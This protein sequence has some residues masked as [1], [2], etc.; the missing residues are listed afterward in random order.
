M[1]KNNQTEIFERIQEVKNKKLTELDLSNLGLK[2][3]PEEVFSL[4]WLTKLTL[5]GI[6]KTVE[7]F[8]NETSWQEEQ[9]IVEEF[10]ENQNEYKEDEIDIYIE[11]EEEKEK[12]KDNDDEFANEMFGWNDYDPVLEIYESESVEAVIE[13]YYYNNIFKEK[14]E[15]STISNNIQNLINLEELDLHNNNLKKFPEKLLKL[16]KL[17]T[18]NLN[19]NFI[20]NIPPEIVQ[21]SNLKQISINSNYIKELPVELNKTTELRTLDISYNRIEDLTPIKD[22][23]LN[24]TIILKFDNN[25]IKNPPLE[26]LNKGTKIIQDWFNSKKIENNEVKMILVGNTT[27]GKT[28]LINFLIS[29][30]YNDLNNSTH[31][32]GINNWQTNGLNINVWDFGGQE[33]Y[34][35]THK[36]FFSNNAVYLLLW[37][38]LN[39]K[40]SLIPTEIKISGKDKREVLELQHYN[41]NHWI[42]TIRTKIAPNSKI[43]LV[44]NKIDE[45]N[46]HEELPESSIIKENNIENHFAI[47]LKK[48]FLNSQTEITD[49]SYDLQF[50]LF[51]NKLLGILKNV[52]KGRK[53]QQYIA[54]IRNAIRDKS[55]EFNILSFNEYKEL[56]INVA[57]EEIS[58]EQI[59]FA[60]TYLHETGV[61]LYYGFSENMPSSILQNYV[62]I[63]P[64]YITSTIY[65]ILDYNVQKNKGKFD[66]EHIIQ[67]LQNKKEALLFS[68]LMQSPNFELIFRYPNKSNIFYATQYLPKEYDGDTEMFE[69]SISSFE[70][71]FALKFKKYFSINFMT[72]FIA[73]YGFYADKKRFWKYG[74]LLTRKKITVFVKCDFE[75]EEIV[76]KTLPQN[77][78]N[79]LIKEI[80]E[81]ITK[82]A[83]NNKNIELS[84][85][86]NKYTPIK[87]IEKY[88]LSEYSF[89]MPKLTEQTEIVNIKNNQ[90]SIL[91]HGN[92]AIQD[93]NGSNVTVNYND[94]IKIEQM[95]H[96][97]ENNQKI[98]HEEIINVLKFLIPEIK[99]LLNTIPI[100]HQIAEF[101]Q[102]GEE[103]KQNQSSIIKNQQEILLG[104]NE[105]KGKIDNQYDFLLKLP[106]NILNTNEIEK[107]IID[108]QNEHSYTIINQILDY[109]DFVFE[110]YSD[111][112]D[113]KLKEIHSDLKKSDNWQTKLKLSIPILN[114][115]GIKFEHEFKLNK[116]IKNIGKNKI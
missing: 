8:K 98:K 102:I 72:K 64:K 55:K 107:V 80:Y 35:A 59:Y 94:I 86:G 116:F 78:D 106:E 25:P 20:D 112:L 88:S 5:G 1:Q 15:I 99:Q 57:K 2:K 28:S 11:N 32:I 27:V 76:V 46:N 73:R 82:I 92:I 95:L 61:L 7:E 110:V 10:V 51:E 79:N 47:S 103:L 13:E 44:Q 18:L 63:K 89:F 77:K 21:L 29:R 96:Q 42:Y 30:K 74:I 114:W 33:Y 49:D 104:Q 54:N 3:I 91:G 37:T 66:L 71:V 26:F 97:F 65:K 43:I 62:F 4:I 109:I 68:E 36:L 84:L 12:D 81:T 85:N 101:N 108:I 23:L 24:E 83:D 70:I 75:K 39:N 38:K 48:A 34:H 9:M 113:I 19:E 93:I 111:E 58:E 100:T 31:G 41:Y 53:I 67:T 50:K 115:I 14:N 60:T 16:S 52:S 90:L 22:I 87:D 45:N 6:P 17:K 69:M 105:I 56:C 40:T